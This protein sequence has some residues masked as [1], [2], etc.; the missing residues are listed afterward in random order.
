MWNIYPDRKKFYTYFPD[1]SCMHRPT[2]VK[3]RYWHSGY[4]TWFPYDRPDR[5]T[6]LFQKIRDDPDDWDDW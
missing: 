1:F 5:R 4:Y 6:Q 3:A 2:L